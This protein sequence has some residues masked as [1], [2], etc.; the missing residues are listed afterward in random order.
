[1]RLLVAIMFLSLAAVLSVRP[2]PKLRFPSKFPVW[3]FTYKQKVKRK[4]S[5]EEELQFVFNLKSQLAGGANLTDALR[6]A[7]TR[8]P[9][10][11]LL[12]TRQALASQV[13]VLPALRKDSE[14][15]KFPLLVNCANL[16]DISSSSGSSINEALNRITQAMINRRKHEQLMSTELASTKATVLV[17]AGLPVMGAGMG[18]ILGT[19]SIS[20][21]FN[22][23]AGRACL[24]LGLMLEMLGWLWIRRLLNV[25]LADVT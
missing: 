12:N 13:E 4:M 2:L 18:L 1:M 14:D 20:W 15:N 16:L 17:L 10:F 8:A 11:A 19:A 25:A 7:V 23:S 5:F 22:S 3:R 9:G 6:L 21:L 24:L